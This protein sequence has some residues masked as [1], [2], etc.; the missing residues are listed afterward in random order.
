MSLIFCLNWSHISKIIFVSWFLLAQLGHVWTFLSFLVF[1]SLL[2]PVIS[3]SFPATKLLSFLPHFYPCNP[4]FLHSCP[5]FP[6]SP[7]VSGLC[8]FMC[9]KYIR[10]EPEKSL[11]LSHFLQVLI[12]HYSSAHVLRIYLTH[13][14][15]CASFPSFLNHSSSLLCLPSLRFVYFHPSTGKTHL[16][17]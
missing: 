14:S 11:T 12:L 17:P 2:S 6:I 13:C 9:C 4:H 16:F 7:F 5:R 8:I 10:K 15:P 3:S 1:S